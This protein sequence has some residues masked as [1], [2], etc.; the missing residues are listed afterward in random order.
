M[1]PQRHKPK[2]TKNNVENKQKDISLLQ[3]LETLQPLPREEN[4][5]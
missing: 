4:S 5:Q 3:H 2:H 1:E